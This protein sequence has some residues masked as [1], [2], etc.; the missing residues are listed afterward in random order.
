MR[1]RVIQREVYFENIFYHIERL[2][3]TATS[4][5][6][7]CVAWITADLLRDLLGGLR[8][9]G[10]A[11]EIVYNA[12]Y[13]NAAIQTFEGEI[14]RTYPIRNWTGGFMHNKFCIIDD[15]ILITGSFNW[16]EHADSSLENA[17]MISGDYR[18]IK[19]YWH[20]FE[21]LKLYSESNNVPRPV[22]YRHND[23]S[24]C[25]SLTYNVGVFG[26][27]DGTSGAQ[28]IAIWNVCSR[29]RRVVYLQSIIVDNSFDD[30]DDLHDLS[31]T[32][33]HESR[34][35]MVEQFHLE[36]RIMSAP[37]GFLKKNIGL[38]VHA[39]GSVQPVPQGYKVSEY[40]DSDYCVDLNWR[41]MYWRKIIPTKLLYGDG[42]VWQIIQS[43]RPGVFSRWS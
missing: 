29:H 15:E 43:Q 30:E 23:D 6:K 24:N 9:K 14:G 13:S 40:S 17:L 11:I 8:N 33:W 20:E 18:L 25:S 1:G 42:D 38:E 7:I 26:Y 34:E 22:R 39:Y 16:T 2:L 4:N 31:Y 3:S 5:V 28:Q 12:S 36:R 21:D 10:V 35:G 27:P 19:S 37:P 41:H 32:D